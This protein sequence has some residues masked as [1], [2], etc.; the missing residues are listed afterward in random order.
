MS[1]VAQGDALESGRDKA[2]DE[3]LFGLLFHPVALWTLLAA[4]LASALA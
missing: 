4:L 1:I 3:G 2:R